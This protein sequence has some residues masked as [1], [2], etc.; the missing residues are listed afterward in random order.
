MR[1]ISLQTARRLAVAAQRLTNPAPA[2]GSMLDIIRQLGCLQLDPVSAVTPS[3]R[4]VLW[5]R[6]G[7]Y[8][9]AELDRLLWEDRRLFEYWAHAASIVLTEDYPIHRETMRRYARGETPWSRRVQGWVHENAALRAHVLRELRRRGPLPARVFEDRSAYA[10]ASGGWNSG[11]NVDRMLAFLWMGGDVMVARRQSGHR[12]WDLSSRCLPAWTPRQRMS[13]AAVVHAAAQ[14]SLRALGVAG[15]ADISHH[16][17]SG[18]YPGLPLALRRLERQ[19]TIIPVAIERE[20]AT[21]D[22]SWYVHA[23]DLTRLD[24]IEAGDWLPRTTLL[25][26]F[27]NLIRD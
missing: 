16:F 23:E 21:L 12:W 20:G 24:R 25:S 19:G 6:L 5:S 2:S 8:D 18:R 17:I 4:L 27:D 13:S 7:G 26:P 14:R 22:G 11:R 3:H 9:S 10:W 1:T 15:A